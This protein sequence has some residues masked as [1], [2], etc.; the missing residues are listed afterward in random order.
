MEGKCPSET[1]HELRDHL[2]QTWRDEILQREEIECILS[3]WVLKLRSSPGFGWQ[4]NCYFCMRQMKLRIWLC[5]TLIMLLSWH[6][7]SSV[8]DERLLF[9]F[10]ILFIEEEENREEKRLSVA[11]QLTEC[12][13]LIS[14]PV[15]GISQIAKRIKLWELGDNVFYH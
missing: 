2:W 1:T 11:G 13:G 5:L 8:L 9:T 10:A 6:T 4:V 12:T 3:S 15:L 7:F 14:L